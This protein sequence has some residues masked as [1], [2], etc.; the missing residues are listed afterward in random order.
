MSTAVEV[1]SLATKESAI[2]LYD[3]RAKAGICVDCGT[4]Q[5]VTN[6]PRCED[7]LAVCRTRYGGGERVRTYRCGYCG[8][9]GHNISSCK[10]AES[11]GGAR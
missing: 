3:Q 10:A 7:C 11:A 8:G 6:G 5:A 1:R 4:E 2:R 9:E